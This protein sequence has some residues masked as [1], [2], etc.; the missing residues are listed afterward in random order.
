MLLFPSCL[1]E[2]P[3]RTGYE[4]MKGNGRRGYGI[5]RL[6]SLSLSLVER[7][8][9]FTRHNKKLGYQEVGHC[10]SYLLMLKIIAAMFRFRVPGSISL[11][12]VSFILD[13]SLPC[14]FR[15][16]NMFR[17]GCVILIKKDGRG[18]KIPTATYTRDGHMSYLVL[19]CLIMGIMEIKNTTQ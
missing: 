10:S 7:D 9:I 8:V 1:H 17:S 11:R 5:A 14:G 4:S 13:P 19:S 3:P 12:F 6:S 15:L 16:G 2:S 18:G